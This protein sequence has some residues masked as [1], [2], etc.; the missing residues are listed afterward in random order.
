VK[1]VAEGYTEN[2]VIKTPDAAKNPQLQDVPF[3]LYTH[4]ATVSV[5]EGDGRGTP[6][7]SVPTDGL[8]VKNTSGDVVFAGDAS[9]MW[10][11]SGKGSAAEQ[12]LGEGGGRREAVMGFSL[13]PDK[14]TITPDK[15][16]LGPD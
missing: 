8:E 14:V 5:A 16:F 3:G 15:A 4:N 1:A 13:T 9:R 10:D 2:L 11:S 12:Q 6:A 7:R